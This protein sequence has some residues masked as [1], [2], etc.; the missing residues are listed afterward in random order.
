MGR[1]RIASPTFVLHKIFWVLETGSQWRNVPSELVSAKTIYHYFR[2]WSQLRVFEDCFYELARRVPQDHVVVDTTFVKN[3]FGKDVLGRNPTDRGRKATKVSLITNQHGTPLSVTFHKAN[4]NDSLTLRH[5]VDTLARKTGI[6]NNIPL[7]A[8]K[9]Y[10]S[11]TCRLVCRNHNLVPHIAARGTADVDR[12]RYVVEQTFGLLDRFR[13]IV[14]RYD[15]S[16]VMFKSF[17]FLA[18]AVIVARR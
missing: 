3:V 2:Q 18:C 11:E 7:Y 15:S 1:P 5:S 17:W 10:D 8:D 9:G 4:R 12:E 6:G 14:L 13:R 16:I